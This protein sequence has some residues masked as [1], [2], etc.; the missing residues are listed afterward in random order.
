MLVFGG[1]DTNGTF[2]NDVWRLS[3][4][5]GLGS[6]QWSQVTPGGTPP[7]A[8]QGQAAV[9]DSA[10]QRMTIFGG[11][12]ASGVLN[13]IGVLTAPGTSPLSCN[14]NGGAPL[15]VRAD[16]LAEAAGDLILNC[17][18]GT[19]TPAGQPIP[20]YNVTLNLNT[21]VTSR[22]LPQGG[23]RSEALAMIDEPF[24]AN[25]VPPTVLLLPSQP[26]QILCKPL[27]ST[28]A[29]TGTG[30][31][32]SPYQ[33]QPNVFVGKQI[34]PAELQWTIPIDPPGVNVVRIIRLTNVRVNANQLG[35]ASGFI[36]TQVQATVGIQG[37]QTVPIAGSRQI[38][39]VGEQGLVQG[40]PEGG[41]IWQCVPHN[42][43]LAGGS[44][45]AAF[46]F[47]VPIAEG[48]GQSFRHRNYGTWIFGLEYPEPLSE[49]NISG[50]TYRTETGFYSPS[51]FTPAPDIGLADTGTR[52]RVEFGAVAAGVHLFVPTTITLTGNYGEGTP[53]GEARLVQTNLNGASV[54]GYTPVQATGMVGTTP[55]AETSRSGSTA[56]AVYE[57]VYADPS[58][59]ETLSIP[60]AVEFQ[61]PPAARQV[62]VT[63]SFAPIGGAATA[64]VLGSL[65]RFVSMY[66]ASPAFAIQSCPASTMS[67][68]IASKSGPDNARTWN[69]KVN[70]GADAAGAAQITSFTLI[71][72]AGAAC[73]AAVSAPA[74][75]ISLGD[76]PAASS[77]TA[78]VTIDFTGCAKSARFWAT[79]GLSANGG[80]SHKTA[81]VVGQA[82]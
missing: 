80:V 71:Q 7:P 61:T 8:R 44:G 43:S 50:Y 41:P 67:A 31:A 66:S 70:S 27:G 52:I 72:T 19:P 77:A 12:N 37:P 40:D 14:A 25:P 24:P 49:Q 74:F 78:P 75:P 21:N 63:P 9:F 51:L 48:F 20:Q 62:N 64:S 2:L 28:C 79:I 5:T 60:V 4:A 10:S 53:Q 11:A 76:I 69:V 81:L 42:A 26:S 68:S 45:T 36:P 57:V 54:P 56:Y 32:P 22:L 39:G 17:T 38:I 55:V 73:T 16:G 18:G 3:N 82:P 47:T 35:L 59:L 58:V 1:E 6:P 13:D 15:V 33:T 30:G 34:G 65:P 46:D 23:E 29:E